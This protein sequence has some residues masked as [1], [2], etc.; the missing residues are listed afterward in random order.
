ML[1]ILRDFK[2][3]NRKAIKNLWNSDINLPGYSFRRPLDFLSLLTF[4]SLSCSL[5]HITFPMRCT[6]LCYDVWADV[7]V[8]SAYL[9]I[10]KIDFYRIR[11]N[12]ILRQHLPP[13]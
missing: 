10:S 7:L 4:N 5:S 8:L 2:K 12:I 1:T 13:A 11:P 6:K 9:K 3:Y